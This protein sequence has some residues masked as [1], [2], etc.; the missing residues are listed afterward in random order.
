MGSITE[1]HLKYVQILRDRG[2]LVLKPKS[3][4][5]MCHVEGYIKTQI[6]HKD[7]GSIFQDKDG[8]FGLYNDFGALHV[9]GIE[10]CD[11][12]LCDAKCWYEWMSPESYE[13]EKVP[14]KYSMSSAQNALNIRAHEIWDD[15]R[16][17]NVFIEEAAE[18]IQAVLHFR[19][20]KCELDNLF[21][22]MADLQI[23]L[24]QMKVVFGQAE[25]DKVL[26]TKYAALDKKLDSIEAGEVIP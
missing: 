22:E 25:F 14:Y 17:Q 3:G 11:L 8:K 10:W 9:T 12:G 6:P 7:A 15:D 16:I 5:P 1:T 23:M 18:A 20:G 4:K 21:G 13:E 24:D 26:T 2:E 19:R